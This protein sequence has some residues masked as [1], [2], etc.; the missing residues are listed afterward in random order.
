MATERIVAGLKGRD[1]DELLVKRAARLAGRG[2][3]KLLAVHVRTPSGTRGDSPRALEDLR[4]TVAGVGGEYHALAGTDVAQSLLDYARSVQATHILVGQ[5]RRRRIA[6]LFRG[7]VESRVVR[8]AGDIDVQVVPRDPAVH[9]LRRVR[10][11]LGRG[12]TLAGFA[13]AAIL[14]AALQLL[15]AVVEHSVATAVLVQLAGAVAVALVGGLWPAVAGALWSSLLVNYFSTPPVGD[16]A[17]HDPQDVLALGVFVGVSVAVAGVVDGSARRSK[18]AA[19]AR[20]EAAT[21]ADLALGASRSEDSLQ[22]LLSE[23]LSV[24]GVAGAAVVTAGPPRHGWELVAG[25]GD[26]AGWEGGPEGAAARTAEELDGGTWLVLFG[27]EIPRAE[28][29]LVDA[30]GVHVRA[31]LERRQLEASRLEISR[32]AEGN[33]MRTAILRAVS[34]DLRTPLAGIKL[35]AGGLLQDGV[36]YGPDERRELLE[37]I[38]ECTDRLDGLVGNLLDMSRIT[39]QSVEPLLEPVRWRD[40]VDHALRTCPP[41]AVTVAL[42]ANM[43][44]VEADPGL[45]ERAIANIVENALKYA[46]GAGITV[47]GTPVQLGGAAPGG[48]PAGELRV[49]DHGPGVPARKVVEMFQPFQRLG[50]ADQGTGI[51]LGLAVAQGFVQAMRGSLDAEETPGGGLTMV[52][53]LPLSAGPPVTGSSDDGRALTGPGAGGTAGGAQE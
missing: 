43:P 33:A 17:I 28:R 46:P 25:A 48:H 2:G 53:R 27:R 4:R 19:L 35:A 26:I 31:R 22:A 29:R 14:P 13:L 20:A 52:I 9:P 15:L 36:G 42:P 10:T 40:A 12:R 5:S 45:L 51:G 38:D 34:H 50:D 11:E 16:L 24:F 18:E 1:D 47:S 41:G 3:G 32:L 44:A 7:S 21:L 39:A 23:S 49:V 30:F 6:G 8:D 37:T